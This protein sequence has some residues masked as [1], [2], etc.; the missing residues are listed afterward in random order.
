MKPLDG[1]ITQLEEEFP[2]FRIRFKDEAWHQRAI[3]RGLRLVGHERY[4]SHFVTVF[5]NTVYW[6][7]EAAFRR[8]DRHTAAVLL[9]ERVHLWDRRREGLWFDAS[10]VAAGP[11]IWTMR[12]HWERRAYAV[13]IVRL[14]QRGRSLAWIQEWLRRLFT[15]VEYAFMW[16][17]PEQ[18]DAWVER[19]AREGLSV[20]TRYPGDEELY[21]S[22]T[23]WLDRLV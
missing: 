9:H 14:T 17:F 21:A 11:A 19:V 5:G 23:E 13:D 12:A 4:L 7:S 6:T 8:D 2:G 16:P 22:T 15:N 10:Y 20:E 18:V 1:L 3:D